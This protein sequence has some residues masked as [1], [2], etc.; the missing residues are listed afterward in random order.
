M[1]LVLTDNAIDWPTENDG[2]ENGLIFV[3]SV[4]DIL[5]VRIMPVWLPIFG[6]INLKGFD[7]D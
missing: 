4:K 1:I 7:E 2:I 5:S 3:N 6:L